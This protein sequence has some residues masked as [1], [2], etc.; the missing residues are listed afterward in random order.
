MGQ[1]VVSVLGH[2]IHVSDLRLFISKVRWSRKF[3]G[4]ERAVSKS[5]SDTNPSGMMRCRHSYG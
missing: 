4:H 1:W 3:A 5:L 2:L